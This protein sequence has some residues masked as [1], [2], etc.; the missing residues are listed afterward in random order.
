MAARAYNK[1]CEAM[2]EFVGESPFWERKKATEIKGELLQLTRAVLKKH[3]IENEEKST[4]YFLAQ[5]AR[6]L[7]REL[8][9]WDKIC[10]RRMTKSTSSRNPFKIHFSRNLPFEVFDVLKVLCESLPNI[11][12]KETKC[13]C[14]FSFA[15]A[16][17]VVEL[18]EK[19]GLKSSESSPLLAKL[20][21]NK[22]YTCLNCRQ[23]RTF[24]IVYSY[25]RESVSVTCYYGLWNAFGIPQHV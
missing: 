10:C 9:Q 16:E 2:D 14:K 7:K 6:M 13:T 18:M 19:A 3:L 21:K 15:F 20:F 11:Q 12:K 22:E 25:S 5:P 24:D 8:T 1:V 17:D 23:D 4:K